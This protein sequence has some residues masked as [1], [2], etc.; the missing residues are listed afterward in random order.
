MLSSDLIRLA[1]VGLLIGGL[2]ALAAARQPII[3]RLW[4]LPLGVAGALGGSMISSAL[5][6]SGF[7]NARTALASLVSFLLV[8]AW[9]LYM[10]ERR[11]P[12]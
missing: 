7:P 9:T 6:G 10:R 2:G 3:I 1:A 8:C 5:L 11:L 12:R 4:G